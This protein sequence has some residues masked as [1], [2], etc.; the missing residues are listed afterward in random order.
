M[1]RRVKWRMGA[2]LGVTK[3]RISF[4]TECLSLIL[5]SYRSILISLGLSWWGHFLERYGLSTRVGATEAE[6]VGSI[7]D[8]Q[9][10]LWV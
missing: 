9:S 7:Q 8:G 1:E 5:T 6:R 2:T 10:Q 3:L 4:K